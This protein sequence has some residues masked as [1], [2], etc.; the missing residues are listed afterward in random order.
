MQKDPASLPDCSA[1]LCQMVAFWVS[2]LEMCMENSEVLAG[3]EQKSALIGM[4]RERK[5]QCCVQ[6]CVC[7]TQVSWLMAAVLEQGKAGQD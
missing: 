7:C 4:M 5:L 1:S 6:C 2:C 3:V